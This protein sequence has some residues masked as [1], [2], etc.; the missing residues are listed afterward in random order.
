MSPFATFIHNTV[1]YAAVAMT[2]IGGQNLYDVE[3]VEL[4][5]GGTV[6]TPAVAFEDGI[7]PTPYTPPAIASAFTDAE[8]AVGYNAGTIANQEAVIEELRTRVS[9]TATETEIIKDSTNKV[10]V[11]DS[12]TTVVVDGATR[13]EFTPA[14][15][16]ITGSISV[17][18]TVDGVDVAALKTTVDGITAGSATEPKFWAYYLAD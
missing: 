15:L 18:G 17:T 9:G 6:T 16:T 5:Y 3:L 2:Y 8:N 10:V 4:D 7:A 13:G 14:G 12:S 1:P 11:S